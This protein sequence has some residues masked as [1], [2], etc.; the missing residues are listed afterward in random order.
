M[1]PTGSLDLY[2]TDQ[3]NRFIEFYDSAGLRTYY[4]TLSR[5]S[6]V[7][8]DNENKGKYIGDLTDYIQDLSSGIRTDS[9]FLIGQST[10]WNSIISV[11]QSII[12]KDK[13]SLNIYYST[14]Q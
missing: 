5:L 4:A 14:I 7:K 3:E 6:F 1:E 11:N 2:F 13:V 8:D 12:S 9:L 10:L